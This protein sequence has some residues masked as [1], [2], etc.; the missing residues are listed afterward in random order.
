MAR[1]TDPSRMGLDVS[2]RALKFMC[3]SPAAG[4]FA[5]KN[6]SCPLGIGIGFGGLFVKKL[7]AAAS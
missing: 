1:I 3:S 7:T 4:A 2:D 5:L 6:S